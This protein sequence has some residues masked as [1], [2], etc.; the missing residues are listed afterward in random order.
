MAAMTFNLSIQA[1]N[2]ACQIRNVTSDWTIARVKTA[3][4]Q[5][6]GIKNGDIILKWTGKTMQDDK[7]LADYRIT[8][9]MHMPLIAVTRVCGG[10]VPIDYHNDWTVMYHKCPVC[11]SKNVNNLSKG[12]WHHPGGDKAYFTTSK[13]N[14]G[15]IV[16]IKETKI[17]CDGCKT[18]YDQTKWQFKC[19]N[20]DYQKI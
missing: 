2:K 20:H 19:S 5:E 12:Y 7:T 4:M 10:G 9:G 8:N 6:M 11:I 16:Q 14:P 3:Y 17:R 1:M 18:E 15:C 13:P